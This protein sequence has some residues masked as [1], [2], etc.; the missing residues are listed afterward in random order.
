MRKCLFPRILRSFGPFKCDAVERTGRVMDTNNA[1]CASAACGVCS[2]CTS[3]TC[4]AFGSGLSRVC[5]S[6]SVLCVLNPAL[7]GNGSDDTP[8]QLI[9]GRV[10]VHWPWF[11]CSTLVP[12]IRHTHFDLTVA[13]RRE[14]MHKVKRKI[15]VFPFDN[16]ECI[17]VCITMP[18]WC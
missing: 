10:R 5:V 14:C 7:D 8:K 16:F 13:H 11:S 6:V 17:L 3:I 9:G 1:L 12:S 15:F 4:C 2:G 18:V